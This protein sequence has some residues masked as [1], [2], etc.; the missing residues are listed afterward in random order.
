[1]F[2]QHPHGFLCFSAWLSFGVGG[3][4]IKRL[5]PE[6]SDGFF[7]TGNKQ[8]FWAPAFREFSLNQGAVQVS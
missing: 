8:V 5:F 2:G 1:M 7:F 4:R 3:E 6:L